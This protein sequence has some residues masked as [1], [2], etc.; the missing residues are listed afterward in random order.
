M[1][2]YEILSVKDNPHLIDEASVWFAGKWNVPISAYIESMNE[3][4]NNDAA[5]P[6]WLVI[7]DGEKIIAGLGV[8][9]NDFHERTDLC[10]NVCAVYVEEEYRNRGIAGILL[11][12][13]VEKL[14]KAGISPVYLLTGHDSFYERYGW[15]FFTM[16]KE[17]D[18]GEGRL[19]IH[20]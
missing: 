4:V 13:A 10:P 20:K 6:D 19:Y 3:A 7:Y 15:E 16:T 9:D 5:Y 14:R 8:I 12:H 11:S 18:G 2:N 17:D 1:N